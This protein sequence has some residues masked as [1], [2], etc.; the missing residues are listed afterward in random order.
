[1][2]ADSL[3]SPPFRSAYRAL[4]KFLWCLETPIIA[5]HNKEKN[6]EILKIKP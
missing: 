3:M 1:M 2:A 5:L 4:G 6:T